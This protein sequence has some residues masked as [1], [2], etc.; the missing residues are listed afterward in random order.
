MQ[1]SQR[2]QG[3]GAFVLGMLLGGV[4]GAIA[5]MWRSPRSGAETRQELVKLASEALASVQRAILGERPVDALAEGKAIARQRRIELS[6]N[7]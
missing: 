6:L 7:K 1:T 4:V 3:E 5:G 2:N